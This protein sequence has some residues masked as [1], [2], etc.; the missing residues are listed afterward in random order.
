MPI[1]STYFRADPYMFHLATVSV[2]RRADV[3]H[4][5]LSRFEVLEQRIVGLR[6][7]QDGS[8]EQCP[9][10]HLLLLRGGHGVP[11]SFTSFA[12]GASGLAMKAKDFAQEAIALP[13]AESRRRDRLDSLPSRLDFVARGFEYQD[14]ELAQA[15]GKVREKAQAGDPKA[16]GELTR[17]KDRQKALSARKDA[18]LAVLKRE[19]ELI[20]AD[21]VAFLAHAL[22]VPTDDPVE[23]KR[24][25]AEVEAIA[26]KVAWAFE[27]A[28][29]AVVK[30]VSKPNLARAVGLG[31]NPGFD[32]LSHRSE[33]QRGIEVKGR[34]GV[35]DVELTENEWVKACNERNRYWLYVV[36]D[37]ATPH[38]RLLRVRDP[39]GKLV[40]KAKGS[41]RIDGAAIFA[42]AEGD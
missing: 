3:S 39:F 36:F 6:Q 30:D 24:F 5:P 28:A 26:V 4:P 22:V 14:A 25:D 29:G 18:A 2:S 1:S 10:E 33:G 20:E 35:G 40:V 42:S 21:K 15:R 37:C 12:S 9:V 17:I 32:L 34:A 23:Q 13:L 31:D 16:K 41:V 11:A 38:P 27:E 7:S 8:V 19:P